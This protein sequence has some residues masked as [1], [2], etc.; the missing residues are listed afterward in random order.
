MFKFLGLQNRPAPRRRPASSPRRFER[1]ED[2]LCLTMP[3]ITSFDTY[4][5]GP[6]KT[7]NLGGMVAD[8]FPLGVTVNFTGVM[9]GSTTVNSS[10][11][12]SYVG[13]A[14]S[15]GTVTATA[16][17]SEGASYRD[18]A[19]RS[20]APWLGFTVQESG[21]DRMVTITGWIFD[22]APGGLTVTFTGVVSGSA[23]ANSGGEFTYTTQASGLGTITATTT[24]VWGLSSSPVNEN[25]ISN[26]PTITYF[27]A[28]ADLDGFWKFEGHVSDEWREGLVVTFGGLL[29]GHTATV[30]ASGYF[31]IMVQMQPGAQGEVTAQ[32]TDWWGLDSNIKSDWVDNI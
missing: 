21:P 11:S 13:T 22:E 2:R 18:A 20:N 5:H 26:A 27:N 19:V 12:F 23:V 1:L 7:V 24:D 6:G 8:D 28:S 15:L 30:N 29:A 14:T 16:S 4:A 17:D 25:V 32:T 9:T 10:G 31:Y 3:W